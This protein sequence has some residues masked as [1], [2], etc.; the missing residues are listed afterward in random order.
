[1]VGRVCDCL[2]HVSKSYRASLCCLCGAKL[3]ILEYL[4]VC[5]QE[6]FLGKQSEE[7]NV[8]SSPFVVSE[9][10]FA[11]VETRAVNNSL[12]RLTAYLRLDTLSHMRYVCSTRKW[13]SHMGHT[14]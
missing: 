14:K 1:M 7:K 12:E 13:L 3:T 6:L 2:R 4:F 8:G 5:S 9:I 10:F 11:E